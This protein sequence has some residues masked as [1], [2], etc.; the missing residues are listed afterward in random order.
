MRWVTAFLLFV[1]LALPVTA[2]AADVD[3]TADPPKPGQE[4]V[5]WCTATGTAGGHTYTM[6]NWAPIDTD[7]EFSPLT[8]ADRVFKDDVQRAFQ[9]K[10]GEPI[11]IERSAIRVSCGR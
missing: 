11:E 10:Y 7:R 9:F 8:Y 3:W 2:F 5:I 6:R 4:P 1:F